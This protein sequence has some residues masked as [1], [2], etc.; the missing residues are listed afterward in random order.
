ML[1]VDAQIHIWKNHKPTNA[2]HRQVADYTAA[3]ALKEMD[4]G[5]VDAALIHPPGWDPDSNALAVEAA[6]AHPR[7]FAILGNFP[8]DKPESRSLIEGWK[9]RP[10]M[11]GLRFALL[12][13]HQQTWLTDGTMEWLWPAAERAGISIAL[14]GAGYVEHIG[15]IAERHPGLRLI[16]DHFGR[17]DAT[18]SVLPAVVA[19]AKHPNIA[20]KATGAPS[21]STEPYPYRDIHGHIHQLYDAYG[22]ERMFWG[23]DITRM[24][25]PWKQCVTMF[26]EE[27]PWLSAKD[28]ELIMGRALCNWIGWNLP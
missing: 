1:V 5:G 2:N 7:R 12:Q 23:T 25:I 19:A 14:I 11:L 21:Y 27:L 3:D 4:A 24:P 16:I 9:S 20:L 28:K 13:P 22:P 10:G 6:R 18:W 8:L 17:P 15:G 26:T